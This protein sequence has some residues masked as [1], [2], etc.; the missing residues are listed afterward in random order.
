VKVLSFNT[1]YFLGYSGTPFDYL[2]NPLRGITGSRT[3][4]DNLQEFLDIVKSE[5]PDF[6]LTQEVD[7]G[8]IRT[9]TS[10]QHEYI[11]SKMPQQFSSKFYTKYR[12]SLF[13]RAPVLRHMGNSVFYKNGSAEKHSLSIGRKN[14]VQEIKHDDF[15]IFSLHLSTF[16]KWIRKQQI[17]EIAQIA[18]SRQDYIIAGDLN[19]HKGDKEINYLEKKLDNPV[20]SPGKTF[21]AKSPTR[22]L[23]LVASSE[24]IEINNLQELGNRFSDHRPIGFEVT[25]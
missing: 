7:G 22:K 14:L 9:S 15:S 13:P 2:K 16:G 17:K 11:A 1:G 3:E 12:G 6:V 20:Y 4:H 25:F 8:S 21:P 18:K 5:E 10:N 24:N 19:L 23:D